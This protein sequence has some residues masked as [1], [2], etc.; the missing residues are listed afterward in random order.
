MSLTDEILRLLGDVDAIPRASDATIE[1]VDPLTAKVGASDVA[2]PVVTLSP[3]QTGDK[4]QV[5]RTSGAA[6]LVLGKVGGRGWQPIG[7]GSV[8][9]V[10]SFDITIPS[11][12]AAYELTLIGHLASS[13]NIGCRVDNDNTDELHRRNCI[14]WQANDGSVTQTINNDSTVW[15]IGHW[16]GVANNASRARIEIEASAGLPFEASAKAVHNAG[17]NNNRTSEAWGSLNSGQSSLGFLRVFG[18]GITCQWRL[19]SYRS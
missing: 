16:S 14:T 10:A 3:V 8:S 1:S 7:S 19:R 2:V 18:D 6:P 12:F 15:T 9:A 11:G 17:N 13:G 5:L 4:V